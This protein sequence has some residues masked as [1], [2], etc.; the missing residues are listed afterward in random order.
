MAVDL[1]AQIE[2]RFRKKLPLSSLIQAP[3]VEQLAFLV[4]GAE[5]RGLIGFDS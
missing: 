4:N 2:Q 1:F 3:T 5:Q